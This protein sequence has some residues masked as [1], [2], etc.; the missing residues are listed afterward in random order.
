M[1]PR[2][3]PRLGIMS[4][5]H[6]NLLRGLSVVALALAFGAV[7]VRAQIG[8][9][10]TTSAASSSVSTTLQWT[11]NVGTKANRILLVGV[12][13]RSDTSSGGAGE[14]TIVNS[15]TIGSTNLACIAAI[16]DNATGSCAHA[17]TGTPVFLRSEIWFV[18]APGSGNSQ[19][20]TVT[21]NNA[22]VIAGISS[23]FFNVIQ[24]TPTGGTSASNNG[25]T[26]SG[27]ATL[28]PLTTSTAM[29][30]V[31][32]LSTARSSSTDT[33]TG[34]NQTNLVATQPQ[35]TASGSFHIHGAGSQ[36]PN[37]GTTTS[38]MRWT[39]STGGP[40]ALVG[41][42]LSPIHKRRGQVVEGSELPDERPFAPF[43]PARKS[44]ALE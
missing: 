36:E 30:V 40:W 27:T 38:T 3:A 1:S 16:D 18:L 8:L 35:D 32:N 39:L 11:H 10:A 6:R 37:T 41:A 12:S 21:T 43:L 22:T 13:L 20:I 34:T 25:V 42:V 9:D 17:A 24:S 28:G 44:L 29:V 26:G 19:T 31:D 7:P 2:R 33:P 14:N 15:V 5:I 23:S 4:G